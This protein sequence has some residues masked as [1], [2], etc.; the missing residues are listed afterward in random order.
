MSDLAETQI[1][2]ET[3]AKLAQSQFDLLKMAIRGTR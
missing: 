1:L 2:Y 3:E